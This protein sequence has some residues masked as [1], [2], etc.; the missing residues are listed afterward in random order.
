MIAIAAGR[1]IVASNIG[2]FGELLKDGVHGALVKP[3]DATALASALAPL[4]ENRQR[5]RQ[6]GQAVREL[7]LAVPDWQKIGQLTE[8]VYRRKNSC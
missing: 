8:D 5:L 1:P 2:L 7:A 6:A 4:I 3:D